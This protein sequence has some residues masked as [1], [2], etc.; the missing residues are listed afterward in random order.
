MGRAMCM[1]RAVWVLRKTWDKCP[2]LS[3]LAHLEVLYK[4][5][6]K[7]KVKLSA[8]WLIVKMCPNMHAK[9]LTKAETPTAFK[10]LKKFLF[11]N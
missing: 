9:I 10:G 3:P 8:G 5:E 11:N 4:S 7:T 2:K 6:I 1:L